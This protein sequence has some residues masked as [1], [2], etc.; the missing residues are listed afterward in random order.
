M[1]IGISLSI[2]K[3]GR[4]F[5][6]SVKGLVERHR[7][8]DQLK[9]VF[10]VYSVTCLFVRHVLML[11]I[12]MMIDAFFFTLVPIIEPNIRSH[13]KQ[14][15]FRLYALNVFDLMCLYFG[16]ICL[17]FFWHFLICV[18]FLSHMFGRGLV[19]IF[20][21][22]PCLHFDIFSLDLA[23]GFDLLWHQ[24]AAIYFNLNLN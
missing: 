1:L 11:S 7:K 3:V 18:T 19:F 23:F 5:V 2:L 8:G 24:L 4:K 14:V 6:F 21:C 12:C 9:L 10:N 16:L 15:V 13:I 20:Y 22:N 17:A